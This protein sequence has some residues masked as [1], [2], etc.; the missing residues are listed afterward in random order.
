MCKLCING[1]ELIL[2]AR[3]LEVFINC[4]LQQPQLSHP[5]L[6]LCKSVTRKQPVCHN[7]GIFYLCHWSAWNSCQQTCVCLC[8]CVFMCLSPLWFLPQVLDG[9]LAQ[10]G[11]V[12]NVEQG[13]ERA[14]KVQCV[15][16][17]SYIQTKTSKGDVAHY[18]LTSSLPPCHYLTMTL[19]CK[20]LD[21]CHRVTVCVCVCVRATNLTLG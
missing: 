4:T 16:L 13:M 5:N 15:R 14:P 11:T 18:D 17:F 10:H 6:N 1:V 3:F 8:D 21:I 12:E 7:C 2:L 9:L 20:E 19:I